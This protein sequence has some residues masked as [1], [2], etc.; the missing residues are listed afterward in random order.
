MSTFY[1][2]LR[3]YS[4]IFK[5]AVLSTYSSTLKNTSTQYL[6]EYC[7]SVLTPSLLRCTDYFIIILMLWNSL[8]DCTLEKNITIYLDHVSFLAHLS[9]RLKGELIVYPCSGVL[10]RPSVVYSETARPIKAKLHL[11]HL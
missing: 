4:S 6:L 5:K 10:G 1:K 9:Q 2:V 3:T 11:D 8:S 7:T